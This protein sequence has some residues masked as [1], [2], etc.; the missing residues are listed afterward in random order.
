MDVAQIQ[1]RFGMYILISHDQN[2]LKLTLP[3]GRQDTK[4]THSA[5]PVMFQADGNT[6][7]H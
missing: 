1:A 4:S 3:L 2:H 7:G 6:K 5:C